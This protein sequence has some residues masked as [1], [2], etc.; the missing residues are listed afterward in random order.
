MNMTL[1]LDKALVHEM[2]SGTPAV[3][4]YHYDQLEIMYNGRSH[5]YT[6][7]QLLEALGLAESYIPRGQRTA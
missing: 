6:R 7:T 1:V 4:D 2:A 3:E 5:Y